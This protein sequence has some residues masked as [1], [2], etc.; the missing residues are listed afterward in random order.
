MTSYKKVQ[1]YYKNFNLPIADHYYSSA[2]RF[3][4]M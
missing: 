2:V 1:I 3:K 4:I